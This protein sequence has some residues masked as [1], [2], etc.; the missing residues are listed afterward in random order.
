MKSII[1]IVLCAL[2]I[3]ASAQQTPDKKRKW[4]KMKD[5]MPLM[6][7]GAGASFQQFKGLKSRMAGFPQYDELKN[8]MY[9]L[10]LGS[11]YVM[12]NFV[13]QMTVTAGSSLTGRADEKSSTM[14]FLAGG[15]DF[16]YD[17]IPAD[18]VML[19]PLVGIG[20][21]T[22]HAIF[23]K[24]VNAVTF[25]D[26]ANSPTAQNNIRSLKL[27]N[28]YVT[29]RLGLGVALKAP[30]SNHTIGL[31][32]GYTGGFKKKSWKTAENQM[33]AGTPRDGLKRFA[34]SLVLTG[35]MMMGK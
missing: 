20:A 11:M 3:S 21:E 13:S 25:N 31:Q 28:Y 7:R 17:V 6:T 19:Y 12:K 30:N 22:Y 35:D 27:I 26:V 9:S 1:L 29:Y 5:H 33:L 16:G 2:T 4:E 10:S 24:D 34:V 15:L 18:R 32:G 14:R 23:Y 8:H